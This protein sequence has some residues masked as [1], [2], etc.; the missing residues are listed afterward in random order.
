MKFRLD[1]SKAGGLALVPFDEAALRALEEQTDAEPV[2]IELLH[3]RD[4]IEHRRIFAQI[5]D[6]AKAL[7]RTPESLRSELLYCTGNFSLVGE[8]V[9][10]PPM[11]A[12]SSMSRHHMKDHELHLFWDEARAVIISRLLPQIEDA[13]ERARLEELLSPQPA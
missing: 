2:E 3:P 1:Q 11:I 5:A 13:A 10:M 7:H 12:V 9:G 8:L 6:V 4:M